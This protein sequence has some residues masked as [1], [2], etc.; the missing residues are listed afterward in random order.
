MTGQP[1]TTARGYANFNTVTY[2]VSSPGTMM[3]SGWTYQ[4]GTYTVPSDS[5]VAY[6]QLY[7]QI[8]G[9][10]SATVV[11]FDDGFITAGTQYYHQDQLSNRLITDVNGNKLGEQGHFPFGESWYT[12]GTSTDLQFTTYERD[13]ES[14]NDYAVRRYYINRLGRFN[15]TD[16]LAGDIGDPQ[17]LNR[18][19]YVR[20]NPLTLTD[21]SGMDPCDDFG[22]DGGG[23]PCDPDFGCDGAGPPV[24]CRECDRQPPMSVPPGGGSAPNAPVGDP[25]PN[26]PFS[27]PI[28]QE[29]GPQI[30]PNLASLILPIDPGCEFGACG[31]G[32]LYNGGGTYGPYWNIALACANSDDP[33]GCWTK[34][35]PQTPTQPQKPPLSQRAKTYFTQYVPCAVSGWITY[36]IGDPEHAKDFFVTNVVIPPVS[37]LKWGPWGVV[38]GATAAASYDFNAAVNIRATCSAQVYGGQQ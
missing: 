26:G 23:F 31:G 17:T 6:V 2:A 22:C 9:A 7:C 1:K 30:A 32:F 16:P 18:Y 14:G 15:S 20:N 13:T 4:V 36:S 35:G 11:N 37:A 24:E 21:P 12:S 27:G 3:S 29:G 25:D 33:L 34:F 10:T 19:A 8:Y 28:W 5:S 38:V